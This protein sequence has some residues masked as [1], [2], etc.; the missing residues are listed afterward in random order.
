MDALDSPESVDELYA[1]WGEDPSFARP[2]MQGDVFFDVT[3]PG[4]SD[5]PQRAQIV[6]HPC[7]MRR[8]ANLVPRVTMAPVADYS[9]LATDWQKR[10]RIMPLPEI[11][12]A[13]SSNAMADL[14]QFTSVASNQLSPSKRVA[15]LS[16]AG[17]L[18]LQQRLV[19]TQTRILLSL[20]RLHEQM[21]PTFTELELQEDWVEEALAA[22]DDS[23]KQEVLGQAAKDFQSWLDEDNRSRRVRL[24]NVREHSRIRREARAECLDRY[25]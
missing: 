9:M 1:S 22:A 21:S 11:S 3:L 23:Q 20:D 2:L 8:G 25:T 12:G 19:F 15:T 7:N 4:I 14:L 18:L 10:F 24:Q 17:V 16:D 5:E 13:G 6:M